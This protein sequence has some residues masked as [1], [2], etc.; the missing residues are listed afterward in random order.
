MKSNVK[1]SRNGM[2]SWR[3]AAAYRSPEVAVILGTI[4]EQPAALEANTQRN[5]ERLT[6]TGLNPTRNEV[7]TKG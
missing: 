4:L 2:K 7:N 5:R 3:E 6:G 1:K